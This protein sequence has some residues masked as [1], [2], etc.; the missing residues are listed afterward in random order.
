MPSAIVVARSGAPES[1]MTD[2]FD[3]RAGVARRDFL[4][5]GA[6]GIAATVVPNSQSFAQGVV[7]QQRAGD[8]GPGVPTITP[9][10]SCPAGRFQGLTI[11]RIS[12]FRGIRYGEAPVG[13]LRW[14]WHYSDLMPRLPFLGTGLSPVLQWLILP[15]FVVSLVHRQLRSR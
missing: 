2:S 1:I 3:N 8:F 10:V 9:V 12:H 7:A 4:A 11:D 13:A 14:S 5:L 15:L 6:G